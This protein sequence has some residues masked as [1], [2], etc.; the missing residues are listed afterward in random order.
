MMEK[1]NKSIDYVFSAI[2]PMGREVRLKETT[3]KIHVTGEDNYRKELIGQESLIERVISDPAVILSDDY[4]DPSN[5]K[6]RYVDI[7]VLPECSSI[8][9]LVVIVDHSNGKYGDIATVIAK[10][11]L[12][13]ESTKGGAIYVRSGSTSIK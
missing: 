3:W 2:D 13:Q 10:K 6:E 9:S 4:A 8:R 7:V 1:T 5:T 11:K 12:Q